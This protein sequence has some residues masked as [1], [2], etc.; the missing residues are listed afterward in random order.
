MNVNMHTFYNQLL[1]LILIIIFP[2]F[3]LAQK[4]S[5]VKP[6]EK[7]V[8][9]DGKQPFFSFLLG[10][11]ELRQSFGSAA[12]KKE[13]VKFQFTL[14]DNHENSFLIDG[15]VGLPFFDVP[16]KKGMEMTGKFI[17]EYHRN[18][19]ITEEQFT[20]QAG[21]ST[22]IRT[23]ILR[24]KTNT[25]FTQLIFTPTLKYSRNVMD[26]VNSFILM[27]DVIPFRSSTKGFNLNTYTIRGNRK[28]INL[29]SVVPAFEL[30][31]NYS[32][33]NEADN[34]TILRPL[35][36]FQYSI[37][38]NKLRFPVTRMVEP[39][40]TWEASVD[41]T[42]RYAIINS[43][44]NREKYTTLLATGVDYY[45]LTLP[46]SV[47][48]GVSF[49]YGSDPLQGLKKQQYWLATLSIQK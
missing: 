22:S 21:L 10:N 3:A 29:L 17:G 46:V 23:R 47:A 12:T 48:F 33:Q 40:K 38:G 34:G 45:F 13:P 14:P 49:H 27:M 19:L 2:Y 35:V 37:G 11:L 18:T 36:K 9:A 7:Q 43:T 44:V 31:H 5:L 20:W 28:L 41:Y 15:A 1:L 39:I 6:T 30:Q 8:F 16:L 32:A 42:I 26:T 24:N 4:D 25:T